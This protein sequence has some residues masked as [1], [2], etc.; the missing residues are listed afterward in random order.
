MMK[1]L[2]F[3]AFYFV[4]TTFATAQSSVTVTITPKAQT[5]T[6][7]KDSFE[8]V[9]YSKL[10]NTATKTKTFTWT[11]ILQQ[12]TPGWTAAICDKN[13]CYTTVVNTMSI[14]L[15]AGEESNLDVHVYP[16]N[17]VGAAIV[18]V[19]VTEK[20]S[21]ANTFTGRYGF[22]L[23]VAVEDLKNV[24]PEIS[25]FPNPTPQYF[26]LKDDQNLVSEVVVFDVSGKGVAVFKTSNGNQFSVAHLAA[27]TYFVALSN[28]K[29]EV[30][31]VVQMVKN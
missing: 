2:L 14:D 25:I 11:K 28:A 3:L 6:A 29:N 17:L 16:N 1:K 8:V 5:R 19:A 18:N 9:L 22:N 26:A 21:S 7:S 12:I 30:L 24:H 27:G 20:D 31:K 15:T 10:K 13:A 4:T 23:P